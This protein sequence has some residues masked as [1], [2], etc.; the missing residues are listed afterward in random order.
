M[1]E[2]V[3]EKEA[4]AASGGGGGQRRRRLRPAAAAALDAFAS[5]SLCRAHG[6]SSLSFLILAV[7]ILFASSP[8]GRETSKS[9]ERER[10]NARR[11]FSLD[12]NTAAGMRIFP[13]PL[14]HALSLAF[15]LSHTH[16]THLVDVPELKAVAQ[17][18]LVGL[19]AL[20]GADAALADAGRLS[21]NEQR[22]G[23]GRSRR[24]KKRSLFEVFFVLLLGSP[25]F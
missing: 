9:A 7:N 5:V 22:K 2:V 18:C 14:F 1:A 15:S 21:H 24:V 17:G 16:T 12:A 3:S 6:N 23:G 10:T 13:T 11:V 25:F 4:T 20:G 8:Y 19:F